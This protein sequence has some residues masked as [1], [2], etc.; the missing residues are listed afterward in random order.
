MKLT[1]R[2]RLTRIFEGKEI[3][4]PAI[5][6][7]GAN[8]YSENGKYLHPDYEKVS[9]LAYEKSDIFLEAKSRFQILGGSRIDEFTETY[10]TDTNDPT[11]KDMHI[12][13][14]TPKGDLSMC[15]RYSLIGE[16]G[17]RTEHLL[18]EP[19]DIEKL[20]SVPYE[21][22]PIDTKQFYN[23]EAALGDRGVTMFS[24]DN[25][26][27][28]LNKL[29]GSE[30]MAYFSI[31]YRDELMHLASVLASRIYDHAKAVLDAGIR[32]PFCWVGPEV[33]IPPLMSPNDFEDFGFRVDKPL[34]DLI[35]NY[36]CHVW[37]HSHGK[38][39]NFIERFI[40]M[41]VDVINP[42][43]PQP[44]GDIHLGDIIEKFGDRIGWEG[45]I[46]IQELLLSSSERI[47]T[48]IDE[49]VS[50]GWKSGRFIMCPSAGYQ[51][52]VF[53]SKQ[54]IENLLVYLQYGYDAVEA[55]R[56]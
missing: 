19:E 28:T 48:M 35:H 6:L 32:A 53:P 23:S 54:Y 12:I 36:G 55:C 22:Y 8:I 1:S 52:Y 33:L 14:H 45:N 44:N 26:G 46:E 16:P 38:V 31:D 37:V 7:W 40:E 2:E 49:C 34:C 50:L 51:E 17:Y 11:R 25:V 42:L 13:L 41:G 39:A 3:D 56:K 47:K 5:K 21:P 24:L 18:K 27:Y 10:T 9:K 29:L 20:L 4:R 43:E 30:A 15:K